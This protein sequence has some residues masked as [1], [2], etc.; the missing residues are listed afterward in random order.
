MTSI[1]Q[2]ILIGAQSGQKLP[3]LTL[4][5]VLHS[6]LH[7][8]QFHVR[9]SVNTCLIISDRIQYLSITL[10]AVNFT[11]SLAGYLLLIAL[12]R[13]S[14]VNIF[15]RQLP[16]SFQKIIPSL[17]A[18]LSLL[19]PLEIIFRYLTYSWRV[20]PDVIVLGEVRCGTV[21]REQSGMMHNRT[22]LYVILTSQIMYLSHT[23]CGILQDIFL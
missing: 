6:I 9:Q 17:G 8:L 1:I 4:F 2:Q 14:I 5:L 10:I 16:S 18:H 15:N 12:Y 19:R 20:L 21:Q 3:Q 11:I 22:A 7:M 13:H 23:R